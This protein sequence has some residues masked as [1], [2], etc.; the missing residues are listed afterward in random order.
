MFGDVSR[1][2]AIQLLVA[3]PVGRCLFLEQKLA[4]FCVFLGNFEKK[5]KIWSA[6]VDPYD[7]FDERITHFPCFRN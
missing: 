1:I 3:S 4:S 5:K 7:A 2:Y 6:Q